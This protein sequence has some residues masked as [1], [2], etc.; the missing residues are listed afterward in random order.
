MYTHIYTHKQNQNSPKKKKKKQ[1]WLTQWAKESKN[2][3]NQLKTK[4]TKAQTGKQNQS[5]V[6]TWE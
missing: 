6:P 5:K 3:I 2:G 4:L 1:K